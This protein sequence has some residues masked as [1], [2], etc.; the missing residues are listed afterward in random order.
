MACARSVG[1]S[2]VCIA[3]DAAARCE[4]CAAVAAQGGGADDDVG[5]IAQR[6]G[7]AR[8]HTN[9]RASRVLHQ[10]ARSVRVVGARGCILRRGG[11]R[12]ISSAA[13]DR[14]QCRGTLGSSWHRCPS[15]T[16]V[17]RA[18]GREHW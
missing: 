10:G 8:A 11:T 9:V 7:C 2:V 18:N 12:C 14:R 1:S 5:V 3:V 13:G 6:S 16:A 17:I 4:Q 15:E